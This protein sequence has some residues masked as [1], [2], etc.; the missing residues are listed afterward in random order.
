MRIMSVERKG[1]FLPA[2][3]AFV[4]LLA[5][6]YQIFIFR[7]S[8]TRG[9]VFPTSSH[10]EKKKKLRRRE[11]R[12]QPP[13]PRKRGLARSDWTASA[14]L[15]LRLSAHIPLKQTDSNA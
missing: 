9:H 3:F 8:E 13:P 14:R 4:L 11:E 5:A 15:C 7:W 6:K 10:H 2:G 1:N 12:A